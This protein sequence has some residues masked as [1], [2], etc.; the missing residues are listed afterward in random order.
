MRVA[1]CADEARYLTDASGGRALGY[2]GKLCIH[3]AQVTLAHRTFTPSTDEVDRARRL[4]AAYD[5]GAA[6]EDATLAFE[7]EMVDE[8]MARGARATLEA[9][10]EC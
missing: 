1:T 2:R 9:A 5:A 3:P 8:P 10:Q 4:L 7:G 6:R